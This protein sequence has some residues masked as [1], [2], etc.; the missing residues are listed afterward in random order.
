[1]RQFGSAKL[2]RWGNETSRKVK[3]NKPHEITREF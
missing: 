3:T 1:M 2:R